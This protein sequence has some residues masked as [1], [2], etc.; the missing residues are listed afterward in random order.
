MRV[1]SSLPSKAAPPS[2]KGAACT[3]L[4]ASCA[5]DAAACAE[6]RR[7]GAVPLL[8]TLV[9]GGT[10]RVAAAAQETLTVLTQRDE[11]GT[12]NEEVGDARPA[13]ST[14]TPFP[15]PTPTVSQPGH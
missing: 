2:L 6:V 5:A 11:G 1:C 4:A 7:L 15:A 8:A 12:T 3:A 10:R 13:P 9:K 14:L